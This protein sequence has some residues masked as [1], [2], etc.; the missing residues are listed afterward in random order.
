MPVNEQTVDSVTIAN[1]KNL[2][3][4]PAIAA[5]LLNQTVAQSLALAAQNAVANQQ[6][7][8]AIG[9]AATTAAVDRL[10]HTQPADA[11]AASKLLT[12][13]DVATQMMQ[14]LSALNSGQQGVKA[15]QTTPP[16]TTGG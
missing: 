5:N 13:N 6:Q 9:Q 7:M 16:D 11:V 2:G 8:N 4:G 15:A 3:D 14:L 1:T 10:L 12:G